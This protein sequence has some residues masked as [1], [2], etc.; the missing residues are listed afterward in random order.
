[1]D[2]MELLQ[3][4]QVKLPVGEKEVGEMM[5]LLLKYKSGKAS[6][7]SRVINAEKWWRLRNTTMEDMD[8]HR[9]RGFRAR[10]SWLHHVITSKHADAMDAY[11]EPNILPR[12]RNDKAESEKLSKI[13]PC[14]LEQNA[15][16]RT[17]SDAWWSKCKFGTGV[18]KIV[19]DASKLGGLGD[20]SIQRCNLLNL[21]WEPGVEDIQE[22]K[23]FFE[24]EWRDEEALRAQ[25]PDV[26]RDGRA[27]PKS[28][29]TRQHII[30]EYK[31]MS[32]KVPLVHAY[33]H[34][35]GMLHYAQFVPGI[36]LYATEN[37]L[38]EP[39]QL[40]P[41]TGAV[42]PGQPGLSERGIYDHGKFPYVFDAL[43][44]V[45]GSPCGYGYVDLCK[46]PQT[47]IDLMKT[48]FVENTMNGARPRYFMR[49]D[50]GINREQFLNL[51][52]P[53]VEVEGT[54]DAGAIAP[55]QHDNLD[56]AY[57]SMLQY[58]VQELRETT[59]NTET[60]TGST[61]AGVTAAS[62]IAALQEAS[63]KGSRDSAM[64]GYRAYSEIVDLAIEL[65]RQFYDLPRQFRIVGDDGTETFT[66]YSNANLREQETGYGTMRLPV[67]DVK[68]TPQKRSAYTKMANN[69]LALQFYNLGFFD[70]QRVDQAV[71]CLTI[72]DFDGKDQL[73]KIIERNGT[74][75]EK[76]QMLLQMAMTMAAQY[77]DAEAMQMLQDIMMRSGAESAALPGMQPEAAGSAPKLDDGSQEP[78]HMRNARSTARGAAM[79]DEGGG[80]A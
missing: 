59:G 60:S 17:Y 51:N 50:S 55:I 70:P 54:L 46:Q 23:Y 63:G 36:V 58:S 26:L 6:I 27:I 66:E 47:E 33:Y 37:D 14:I 32:D 1:M 73:Q 4:Q 72:M 12:E 24:V 13:I 76:L 53:L 29:I 69:E 30:D 7:D 62:A 21:F 75:Y 3:E 44:P 2:E 16:E 28:P 11:P 68:I 74:M 22:S 19:W 35:G 8:G 5:A 78:T 40:D 9:K 41:M 52:N 67:F 57:I 45:E 43:F 18:Y 80:I 48:A 38:G 56:A 42:T 39:E 25:Y 31:D 71:A 77:R 20:I 79:P 10:S 65:V 61:S 15:F 34:K 64:S 49:R